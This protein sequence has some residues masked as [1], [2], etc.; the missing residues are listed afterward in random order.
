MTD[1]GTGATD[2]LADL[3][4]RP[5]AR[6][7]ASIGEVW[8]S[9]WNRSGLDTLTGI[10]AP[11]D[12][13]YADLV[14]GVEGAAGKPVADLVP[15]INDSASTDERARMLRGAVADLPE[16]KRAA[17]EPLFDV[18]RRASEKALKTENDANDV[19]SA[20]YGISGVATSW[21]AGI[22]RQALDPVNLATLPLGGP[23]KGPVA[24]VL[25]REAGIGGLTQLAQEPAI[26]TGRAQ[27]GLEAGFGRGA[28]NV[29]QAAVGAAGLTGLFR[30]AAWALRATGRAGEVAGARPGEAA[31][32]DSGGGRN[33]APTD[34][35]GPIALPEDLAA[36][37]HVAERDRMLDLAAVIQDPG[38]LADHHARLESASAALNAGKEVGERPA[39]AADLLPTLE[40]TGARISPQFERLSELQLGEIAGRHAAFQ[41]DAVAARGALDLQAEKVA[42]REVTLSD[43]AA[44][45]DRLREQVDSLRRDVATNEQ[46][47]RDARPPTDPETEARLGAIDAEL[48]APALPARRRQALETERASITETLAATAPADTRLLASLEQERT[49]LARATQRAQKALDRATG[50]RDKVAGDI[51]GRKADIA[52]SQAQTDAHLAS[53]REI[54]SNEMRRSVAR[55]AAEGYGVRLSRDEAQAIADRVLGAGEKDLPTTLA[56]VSD[57]LAQLA[58]VAR[59]EASEQVMTRLQGL[60]RLNGR[61]LSKEAARAAAERLAKANPDESVALLAEIMGRDVRPVRVEDL[62]FPKSEKVAPAAAAETRG[63]N[64]DRATTGEGRTQ[65]GSERHQT[66]INVDPVA[67]DRAFKETSRSFY[68]LPAA[69]MESLKAHVATGG[70]VSVPEIALTTGKRPGRIDFINGRHRARLAAEMGLESIPVAVDRGQ[71][72]AMRKLL[73][74]HAPE[75]KPAA[76]AAPPPKVATSP[77]DVAAPAAP[78]L[79]GDPIIAKE[80][81]RVIAETGDM[82]IHLGDRRMKISEAMK[83]AE[84]D[85]TAARELND[86]IGAAA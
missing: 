73:S 72:D 43:T 34:S 36:A 32:L 53:N 23:L 12:A 76:A 41:A 44:S 3:A 67:L 42:K 75:P 62:P 55:L 83:L 4:R 22:A 45:T 33:N 31:A 78:K 58:Q 74:Q 6:S 11:L 40:A 7:P 35:A 85:A 48:A 66:I 15:G 70:K 81:E 68:D 29:A 8:S 18:R 52:A 69:A 47:I 38:G 20:A 56:G 13:A 49:G 19:Y 60:A 21:A 84:N 10:G 14:K 28:A 79:G 37:A 26:E 30:A 39:T 1:W 63:I 82:E 25:L 61:D 57:E 2:Y 80:F 65:I 27:L 59:A 54:T 77:S 16:E 17:L 50:A 64:W 46:K 86:C 71:E 9:E 51:A 24:K 5:A